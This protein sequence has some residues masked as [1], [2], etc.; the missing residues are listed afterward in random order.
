MA[1]QGLRKKEGAKKR[2]R[3]TRIATKPFFQVSVVYL[4]PGNIRGDGQVHPERTILTRELTQIRTSRSPSGRRP[5][6][7]LKDHHRSITVQCGTFN[8]IRRQ[9]PQT[10]VPQ[11][12]AGR[13][14]VVQDP[15]DKAIEGATLAPALK[16]EK[17]GFDLEIDIGEWSLD[18]VRKIVREA[19]QGVFHAEADFDGVPVRDET[20]EGG[21]EL[22][23]WVHLCGHEHKFSHW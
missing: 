6:H 13:E 14:L 16:T 17:L 2:E 11:P 1:T 19:R 9:H 3:L 10:P 21:W 4:C 15:L 18:L 23:R 12:D 20:H 5:H 8:L 22:S 7:L